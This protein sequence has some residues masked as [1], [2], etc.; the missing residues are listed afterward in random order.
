VQEPSPLPVQPALS[1][2]LRRYLYLTAAATGA[3][4]MV[5]EILGAKMMSPFV[6]LSH[7]VWTAQIA[8]TLVALAGG[9][10][11]GGRLADRS[12]NLGTLYRAIL[13]A[14]GYLVLTVRICEPVAY[15]CLD[16]NLAVGSLLASTILFFIPLALLAM[17]GPFLV[18][19]VTSSVA[20]VGGNVGRLT[21]IGTLGSFAGTMCI[22]YVML[23]LLPNSVSMYLT[24]AALAL[25]AAGYFVFFHRRSGALLVVAMG[26]VA[27][28]GWLAGHPPTHKYTWAIVRFS[29]NSYFGQ[30]QVLDYPNGNLRLFSNDNLIQNTYDPVRKQGVSSFTFL[31]TG[32]ARAC[33][34]NINDALCIGLGVGITPMEF[35]R[36]GTR[37][38]V[39]E[40]NPAIVPFAVRF[41]DLEPDKLH[42]TID[43]GRHFLNRCRKQYDVVVLDAFLGDSSPS[44]LM[45]RE[46][47]AAIHRVLR[48]G[49][50][51]VINAFCRPEVG[52]DFF[53]ASLDKTLKT[54]FASVRM[55]NDGAQSYYVATDRPGP[56]FVRPP[57]L[58]RVRPN[59]QAQVKAAFANVV[60][61]SP[62]HGRVL[63]D[64]Y[65][66]VEFYDARNRE[67]L[68]RNFALGMRNL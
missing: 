13:A 48:P 20:G 68:R 25:V 42:I 3:A 65:N 6:G 60:E 34:T 54:V 14:A 35:A 10:Y 1:K 39:V 49:G 2:G 28:T 19:V 62:G 58:D 17:T 16:F 33:T 37:V 15:W 11:V 66:P 44:H 51:L 47:F 32:L 22:G 23:P 64:D 52:H 46:A 40:I 53:A 24:A 5:V 30:L 43:D 27:G 21:S 18:R 63:T 38:D 41:F 31:L 12:Q 45:T 29:G 57:E 8:V 59:V 7:F 67:E 55:H 61:P 9:Y 50:T 36:Q 56:E 4:V 26:L